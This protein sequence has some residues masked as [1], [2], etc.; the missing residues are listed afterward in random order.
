MLHYP[1]VFRLVHFLEKG[2]RVF[3]SPRFRDGSRRGFFYAYFSTIS[4]IACRSRGA[5]R[6]GG[7]S[8][9]F[10]ALRGSCSLHLFFPVHAAFPLLSTLRRT[11]PLVIY[12]CLPDILD[13]S[14]SSSDFPLL[15]IVAYRI[16][17][18]NHGIV[19]MRFTRSFR[20]LAL[21]LGDIPVWLAQSGPGLDII[22]ADIGYYYRLIQPLCIACICD[23]N[24]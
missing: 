21:F 8:A 19:R 1:Q 2:K 14:R 3:K 6:E 10:L 17:R 16:S 11:I 13:Q 5:G 15:F 20:F 24:I 7:E 18:N 4:R 22:V 23:A 12:R 9:I